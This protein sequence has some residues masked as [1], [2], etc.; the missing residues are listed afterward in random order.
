MGIAAVNISGKTIQSFFRIKQV[1]AAFQESMPPLNDLDLFQLRELFRVGYPLNSDRKCILIIDEIS[2]VRAS[3]LAAVDF[4]MKEIT[5]AM[6]RAF[7]GIAVYLFGDF[8]QLDPIKGS[9][10]VV[11]CMRY[12]FHAITANRHGYNQ[13]HINQIVL[14]K[15][16]TTNH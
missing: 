6:D 13:S 9:S 10:L 4:W 3:L 15:H 7:G 16:N 8:C 1:P 5:G 11:S 12:H 2:M 14:C